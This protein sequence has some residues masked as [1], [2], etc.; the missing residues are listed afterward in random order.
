MAI[1]PLK[2]PQGL[3][4]KPAGS[5][6][7][8]PKPKL[9]PK[10]TIG[11]F[12]KVEVKAKVKP[13]GAFAKAQTEFT[14]YEEKRNAPWRKSIPVGGSSE[15]YFLDRGEPWTRYEHNIGGGPNSKG[16]I[17]PCIKDGPENCPA[18]SKENK[19]GAF[20]MFLTS[21]TPKESWEDRKTGEKK[22]ARWRKQLFPIKIKMTKKYQRLYEAHGTFRGMV[23]KVSRDNKMDAGTGNDVEFVRMM[24][25]A[26]IQEI[27]KKIPNVKDVQQRKL[28]T[29]SNITEAYDYAKIMPMP[30]AKKLSAMVGAAFHGGGAGSSDFEEDEE[31][32][33][34]TGWSDDDED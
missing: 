13:G 29:D 3:G 31:T 2:R 6:G 16:T 20:V 27:A 4:L 1:K 9:K 24:T 26:E 15:L 28:I 23:V 32:S 10:A 14:L 33:G 34:A 8:K 11:S 12:G 5:V 25:E 21:V 18:C 17:V 22:T 30:D 19:E 7:L